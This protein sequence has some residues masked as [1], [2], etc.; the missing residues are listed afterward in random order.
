MWIQNLKKDSLGNVPNSSSAEINAVYERQV[1]F[2]HPVHIMY[3][4]KII[5]DAWKSSPSMESDA[6]QSKGAYQQNMQ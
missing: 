1:A 5:L 2:Y 4:L 3:F 6:H